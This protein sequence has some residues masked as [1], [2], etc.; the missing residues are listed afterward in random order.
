MLNINKKIVFV[1]N[2]DW[3]FNL[4]WLDRANYFRSLGYTIHVVSNFTDKEIKNSLSNRGYICHNFTFKRKSLNPLKEIFSLIYLREL[5][6]SINPDLIHCITVKPNIY[7][8]LLNK[9]FFGKPIVFSIT[10]LGIIF[11]SKKKKFLF[12]KKII[13]FLYRQVSSK[14]SHFIF[15]NG[16][17]LDLFQN[18]GVLQY[19]NGSLI[20]GAGIDMDL[21]VPSSPPLTG[22]I[23]FAARLLE[24]KGLACLI[25]A[26]HILNKDGYNFIL[27]VAGIIDD[28]VSSA[29]PL[30]QIEAWE[31]KGDI[32]W[33]GNV[34]DMPKLIAQNDVIC[35][36][37]TYGEGVPRILIEAASCQRAIVASDVVGCRE[38]VLHNYNGYLVTPNNAVSLANYLRLLLVDS[39]K[40]ET[41]GINGR[42]KVQNEFSQEEVFKKTLAVYQNLL[43]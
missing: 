14:C 22:S 20:K 27:N 5:I 36:P 42:R 13:T 31:K 21:F 40:L 16:E 28:D 11:S 8:G 3:Y 32:N 7:L 12:L 33:L 6:S 38:I 29:I 30:S 39:D 41:F 4:H 34:K 23:L 24:D 35:L 17:D 2:V 26:N 19:Q 43:G 25:E 37:T 9:L 1:I 18:L 10:G 15:E